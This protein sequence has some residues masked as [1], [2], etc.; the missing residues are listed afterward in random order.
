MR[1]ECLCWEILEVK[2]NDDAGMGMNCGGQDVPIIFI[3][4]L[5]RFDQ[6]V[7]SL[8][9]AILRRGI[10]QSS[11]LFKLLSFQVGAIIEQISDPLVVNAIGPL[12]LE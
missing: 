8:H 9:E 3:R 5:N 1:S 12:G 11:C 2:G 4:E 6:A 10:H 7:I